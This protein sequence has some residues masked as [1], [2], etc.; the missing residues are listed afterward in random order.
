MRNRAEKLKQDRAQ[1]A[2]QVKPD[3]QPAS[4]AKAQ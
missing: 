1:T 4:K 2:T 3:A